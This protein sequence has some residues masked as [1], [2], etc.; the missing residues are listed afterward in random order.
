MIRE[1]FEKEILVFGCGNVLFGDDGFGPGVIAHLKERYPLPENVAAVD[2]GTGIRN[3]LFD[4]LLFPV[5]PKQIFIIDAVCRESRQAGEIFE[6]G[7]EE[8]P[9]QKINDFSLHQFPS[10]NLLD[11]LK[12]AAGINV[13]VLAAQV[14]EIPAEVRPGISQAVGAAI[15]K[16][17]G[18]ILKQLEGVS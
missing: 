16:A 2:V 13:R 6:L 15:P 11:E 7:I 1:I 8:L 3:L 10:V 17:C 18:W 9:V 12:N 14:E 4:L 5:K